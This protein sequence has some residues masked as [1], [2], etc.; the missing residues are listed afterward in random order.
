MLPDS[1]IERFSLRQGAIVPALTLYVETAPDGTPLKRHSRLVSVPVAANLRLDAIGEHFAQDAVPGEPEWTDELRTLWR[2][3]QKL[4]AARGRSEAPRI[5]YN[6][7]IDWEAA[8]EGRVTIVPRPRGSPLDKLVAELMIH[9][10]ES[11]G[12]MLV[13]VGVP[14]LYRTQQMGKVKMSTR[15]EP[16]QGLGVA[17]YLWASS[18]LRRYSDLVNQQQLLAVLAGTPPPYTEGDAELYAAMTDFEVTYAQY[19]EFQ[20]RMERYWCLRWLKQENVTEAAA[21]VMRENLVRLDAVPLYLRLADL[22]TSVLDARVR[23]SVGRIDLL[24]ATVEA[25]FAG[26]AGA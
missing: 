2:L 9:V 10:N 24:A 26:P 14:G 25:R 6:F 23:V 7:Y 21:T 19:A 4:E 13:D 16:H 3:A 12:A 22:P 5:D 11:W 18:P 15:P 17:Q 20:D 1:V 8:P